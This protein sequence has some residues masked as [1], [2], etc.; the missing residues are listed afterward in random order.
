MKKLF[1]TIAVALAL[2]G[3]GMSKEEIASTVQLSM[4]QK[5]DTDPQFNKYGL[6][7]E[8]VQVLK[9]SENQYQGLVKVRHAGEAHDVSVQ[10]TVDG[11][12]V[13]WTSQPG[14][15]MFVAQK[16]FQKLLGAQ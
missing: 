3:C 6:K 15:F 1:C 7:V 13:M 12:S 11:Q 4:Q 16:E 8:G 9:Q 2:A 5:L 10:V 14:A